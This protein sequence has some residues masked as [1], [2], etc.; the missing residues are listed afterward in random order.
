MSDH[1]F[2]MTTMPSSRPADYYLGYMEGS[3]FL[4]FNNIAS[5]QVSLIRISFDGYGC[6][7]LGRDSTPLNEDDSRTFMR[8]VQEKITEQKALLAI[9]KQAINLNKDLIWSDALKE[10]YLT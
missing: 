3:V 5:N 4:D 10:Y 8:I 6:C 9:V 2:F 7:E 1:S